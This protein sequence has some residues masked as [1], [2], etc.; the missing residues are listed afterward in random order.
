MYGVHKIGNYYY[1]LTENVLA[2]DYKVYINNR[3]YD[4]DNLGKGILLSNNYK[5]RRDLDV[6]VPSFKFQL[7]I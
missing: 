6:D 2:K 5:L 3:L 7:Q 4:F 1:N